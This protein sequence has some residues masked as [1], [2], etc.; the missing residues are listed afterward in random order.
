MLSLLPANGETFQIELYFLDLGLLLT[1]CYC[2]Q[3]ILHFD[4]LL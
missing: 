1:Y 3:C 4:N 2:L